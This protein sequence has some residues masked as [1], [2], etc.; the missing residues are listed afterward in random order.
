MSTHAP[1]SA[2]SLMLVMM[3]LLY[4]ALGQKQ[5]SGTFLPLKSPSET[6]FVII[7]IDI[8]VALGYAALADTNKNIY[9]T[10]YQYKNGTMKF[11]FDEGDLEPLMKKYPKKI[12][13]KTFNKVKVNK[14]MTQLT[15]V[16]L[17]KK[18]RIYEKAH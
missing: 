16:Y 17:D 6:D 3:L 14:K 13:N 5:P 12:G 9:F 1:L 2:S 10:D 15:V 11:I 18:P 7:E 4:M 8:D